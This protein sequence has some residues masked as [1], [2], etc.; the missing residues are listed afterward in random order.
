M[1]TPMMMRRITREASPGLV[2][3]KYKDVG[4]LQSK[5]GAEAK[6]ERVE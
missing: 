5:G 2:Q 4:N 1:M 3:S 6:R